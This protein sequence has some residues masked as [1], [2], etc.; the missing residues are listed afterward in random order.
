M[1]KTGLHTPDVGSYGK[2]NFGITAALLFLTLVLMNPNTWSAFNNPEFHGAFLHLIPAPGHL[3]TSILWHFKV[4]CN[5]L[6]R[7]CSHRKA[8][9]HKLSLLRQTLMWFM[10]ASAHFLVIEFYVENII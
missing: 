8:D 10:E 7:M 9:P 2:Y 5:F 1:S 6:G 4:S 3:S